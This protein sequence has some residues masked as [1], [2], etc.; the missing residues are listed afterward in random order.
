MD[1]QSIKVNTRSQ[2][3][4]GPARRK[5]SAGSIPAV[6]YGENQEAVS[7]AVNA[8]EF[9][10]LV[11]GSQGEH[12]VLQVV[13]ED[14]PEL[15]GPSMIKAV[16]YHPIREHV[17]HADFLRI[18]LDETIQTL[19]PINITGRCKGI[20]EGGVPDQQLRE[21]EIECLP[22]YVPEQFDVDIT[23]LHIGDLLHVSD[24]TAPE[25]V[26]FLTDPERTIIAIQAPRVATAEETGEDEEVAEGAAEGAAEE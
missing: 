10:H 13:V 2:T 16:Q 6:L 23:E 24:L 26:T 19:I 15:S 7:I 12:A 17:I 25:N 11:H 1:I 5:R 22:L 14:R 21:L 18:K 8:K 4:K 20:V 9:E 3:G